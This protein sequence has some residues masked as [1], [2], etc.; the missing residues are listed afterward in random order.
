MSRPA[1]TLLLTRPRAQSER[2]ADAFS[3]RCGAQGIVIAPL[4]EIVPQTLDMN[5]VAE[6]AALIFTSENGVEGFVTQC[7]RRDLTAYC[8]GPRT[9]SAAEREGFEVVQAEGDAEAL[10]A[11]LLA[12]QPPQPLLHVHGTHAAGNLAARL[13]DAGL[14]TLETIVYD[15]CA[16]PLDPAARAL[17]ES[18]GTVA[19]PLFS[20]RSARLLLEALAG[21]TLLAQLRPLAISPAAAEVWAEARPEAPAISARPDAEAM[22]DALAEWFP[23]AA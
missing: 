7:A 10:F 11:L 1:P 16:R 18:P 23:P 17:L 8:V 9:A 15:Q 14:R 22:L 2:F 5:A 12:A 4:M 19:L 21:L 13:N 6:A 20:P 3:C